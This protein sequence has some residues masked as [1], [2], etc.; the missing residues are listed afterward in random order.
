MS[1]QSPLVSI[2]VAAYN[3]EHYLPR[4][5]DSLQSQTYSNI[6][7]IIINDASTDGTQSVIDDYA[8][9][10]QRIVPLMME[11]NSGAPA[12]RNKGMKISKGTFLTMIDADDTISS[13]A[14]ELSVRDMM[15]DEEIDFVVYA[16][17][18]VFTGNAKNEEQ[19]TRKP[20]IIRQ[21]IPMVMSGSEACYWSM[22]WDIPGLGM[23]RVPL[24]NDMPADSSFGQYGD[25]TIT[26][27][28][29]NKARKVKLGRGVYYYYN[30]PTSYTNNISIKR[31]E[32]L[33]CRLDLIR[34]LKEAGVDR[35]TLQRLEPRRWKEFIN[36]C[37]LYWR[38]CK[39]FSSEERKQLYRRLSSTYSTF[40]FAS[41]PLSMTLKPRFM[42]LP[43]FYMF[44]MQAALV[45][46]LHLSNIKEQ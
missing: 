13:D 5:L 32:I 4:C 25:E 39:A 35:R 26:H 19:Y 6:E 28:I 43:T 8:K 18:E 12:A 2:I 22:Q 29:L 42:M 27:L 3:A 38:Y 46:S 21:E 31:F 37:Y 1:N 41:L 10:D 30:N 14:I 36:A 15:D 44:Y 16:I 45:W 40:N 9:R 17:E 24:E 34:K 11:R 20:F 33:E 23:S 7:I